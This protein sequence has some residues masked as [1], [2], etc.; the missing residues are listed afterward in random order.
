MIDAQGLGRTFG[1]KEIFTGIDFSVPKG[2]S[3]C[4]LGPSGCGKST[5]LHIL[6]GLDRGYAGR[7]EITAGTRSSYVL[8]DYGLF[9]W[10]TVAENIGL[11]LLLRGE[12]PAD[13]RLQV[14]KMLADLGLDGLERRF[15][16]K[17][18]GGQKQRVAI[19]RALITDPDLLLL[20]EPFSSLDA[21]TREHLQ[22]LLSELRARRRFS[23]VLATHSIDEAVF[24]GQTILV[25][26][27]N[28]TQVHAAF[29]GS[30]R[31]SKEFRAHED[32]FRLTQAVRA[33]LRDS[34][35]AFAEA[36]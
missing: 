27:G 29:T 12:K 13:V 3:I 22:N 9:P 36:G 5:I 28:P 2:G 18:S 20:D 35:P 26:G 8:Q 17:L 33:A 25:L 10:K 31:A 15:P 21:I 24:L 30:D 4:L 16:A 6:A 34:A 7:L 32:F 11:P 23:M 1:G 14:G 19:G